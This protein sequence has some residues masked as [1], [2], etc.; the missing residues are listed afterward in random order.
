MKLSNT[1]M[2]KIFNA[3]DLDNSGSV[4]YSGYL[5]SF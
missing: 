5:L 3:M 2:Q 4:D 1:D